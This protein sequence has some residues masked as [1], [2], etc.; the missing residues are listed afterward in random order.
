MSGR[1]SEARELTSLP[2][3]VGALS[4]L[5]SLNLSCCTSLASLPADALLPLLLESTR[6]EL[7]EAG[8]RVVL[9]PM[10]STT[11]LA[12]SLHDLERVL[13][14]LPQTRLT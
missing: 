8:I 12:D 7:T 5:T 4:S 14:A 10:P 6:A 2:A 9:S 1:P 11:E 3:E 13:R